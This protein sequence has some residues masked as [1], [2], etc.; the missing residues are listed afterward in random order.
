MTAGPTGPTAAVP[1]GRLNDLVD[2][3][4]HCAQIDRSES[5][6]KLWQ[7]I[8]G[9][10]NVELD[11][12]RFGVTPHVYDEAMERLYR[13]SDA[14]IF[15]TLLYGQ[16]AERQAWIEAAYARIER[17]ARELRL[18][19]SALR[20]LIFGDGCGQDTLFLAKRGCRVDYFDIPGSRTFAFAQRRF[21]RHGLLGG[22]VR[23][24]TDLTPCAGAYDAVLSFE[25]LEHMPQP[26]E[27]I[28]AVARAL[29]C[30]GIA[31]ITEAFDCVNPRFPTHLAANAA[32][33]DATAFL[34]ARD[35]LALTWSNAAHPGKPMEFR[36]RPASLRATVGTMV[37]SRWTLRSWLV[38][39]W[40]RRWRDAALV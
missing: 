37:R 9:P 20:I 7:Q 12:I 36:R 25:V 10:G 31:L 5:E 33:R 13:E 21:A 2:E 22:G 3:I 8:V 19:V 32:L 23:V 35:G 17:H 27:G 6:A 30:G 34:C 11:A 16:R 26:R 4:A 18:P 1:P 38:L 39:L 15:E 28:R 40:R 29:K 14:F 24:R